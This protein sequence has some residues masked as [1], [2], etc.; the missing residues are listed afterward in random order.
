LRY[1][2]A[3]DISDNKR[4]ARLVRRLESLGERVQRSVFEADLPAG[5]L[6]RL[7]A[8]MERIID[9]VVDGI[10]IYRLCGECAATVRILG[11]ERLVE[12]PGV[13]IV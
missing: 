7:L 4:R 11:Q 1:V 2:I 13:T 9:P 3:Y 5:E 6:E 8:R 10:R 12:P